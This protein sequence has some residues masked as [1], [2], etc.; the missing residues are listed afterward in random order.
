MVLDP[1]NLLDLIRVRE[2]AGVD[3]LLGKY[4]IVQLMLSKAVARFRIVQ[5][6]R[7]NFQVIGLQVLNS[8]LKERATHCGT[9]HPYEVRLWLQL[10]WDVR[11]VRAASVCPAAWESNLLEGPLLQQ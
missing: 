1:G 7:D 6:A 2:E 4:Y 11:V 3:V 8:E 5:D 9:T 10:L